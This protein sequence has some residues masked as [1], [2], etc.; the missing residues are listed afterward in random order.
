MATRLSI[1]SSLSRPYISSS[2]FEEEPIYAQ[3]TLQPIA[4]TAPN[5]R[6]PLNIVLVLD[7]SGTMYNF[8]LTNDER[9]YW[10]GLALSRDEMERGEADAQEA[11]FWSGQTLIDMQS[12]VR[13]PMT[14]AVN[15]IKELLHSIQFGDKISV[16]AFA[17]HSA[18]IFTAD[19]W[20]RS[21]DLCLGKLDRLAQQDMSAEIGTGTKMSS[22]LRTALDMV[23]Q[24]SATNS[25]NRII[26]I[27]DGMVQD[28]GLTNATVEAIQSSGI[29]ITSIGV[30][31]DFDEEFLMHVADTTRGGYY[32]AADV[33]TITSQLM[34][35]MVVIQSTS[36]KQLYIAVKGLSNTVVQ[37]IYMARPNMTIFDEINA[38]DGWI[39]ARVGDLPSD[40]ST[41]LLI[42]IAP[43]MLPEGEHDIA[44]VE[45]SWQSLAG[46]AAL[47]PPSSQSAVI[48]AKYTDDPALL[49]EVNQ[50]VKQLVDR[51]TV[52]RYE[53]EAQRAQEKGDFDTA[54]EKLGAA[55]RQLRDLGENSLA[56]DLDQEIVSLG[57]AANDPNRVK[58]IKA[59][60][61]KLGSGSPKSGTEPLIP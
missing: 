61:R 33:Q 52:Y 10:M 39:Q 16:I 36:V 43:A 46:N 1:S 55:T 38:E 29:A 15:A 48:S 8:Q 34:S 9:E 3:F 30:G 42:Q 60:T 18:T 14:V 49:S 4:E 35:E 21:S 44:S 45:L 31:D 2:K 7:S 11:V 6:S 51:L 56:D 59:T 26:L 28:Q 20:Q 23:H 54:K 37:D 58:R 40:M 25:V 5:Q 17:D 13:K 41:T 32:Y 19:E 50:D 12:V 47:T 24:N 53:R 22:P 57:T 27:S